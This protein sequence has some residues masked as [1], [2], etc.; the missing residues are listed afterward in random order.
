MHEDALAVIYWGF[1]RPDGAEEVVRLVVGPVELRRHDVA[2]VLV[3]DVGLVAAASIRAELMALILLHK[4]PIGC[5]INMIF[6]S[7]YPVL[8]SYS[9][10]KKKECVYENF[11]GKYCD[12]RQQR[13]Q[14]HG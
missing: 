10:S 6:P 7:F 9:I 12:T 14:N 5:M 13:R 8:N 4:P 1:C 2:V 3:G 11:A